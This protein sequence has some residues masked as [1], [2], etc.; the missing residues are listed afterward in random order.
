M[1]HISDWFIMIIVGILFVVWVYRRFYIWLHEPVGSQLI[2]LDGGDEPDPGDENVR[3]LEIEGYTVTSARHRVPVS[4]ELDGEMLGSRLYIDYVAEKDSELYLVKTARDRMP[5][6]W[7]GSGIRDRLLVY[8]LLVPSS[9]GVLYV[10]AKHRQ[11]RVIRFHV[12]E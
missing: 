7:T 10:D 11:I 6:D 1:G 5:I 9:S 4:V 8:T 3:L 12:N 2:M